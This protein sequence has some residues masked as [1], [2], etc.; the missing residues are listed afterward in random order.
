MQLFYEKGVIF[1]ARIDIF[2]QEIKLVFKSAIELKV[3]KYK[4]F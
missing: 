3:Q 4:L 2:M 1:T